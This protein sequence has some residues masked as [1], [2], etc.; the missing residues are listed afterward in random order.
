MEETIL[1]RNFLYLLVP[2]A[3]CLA[4]LSGCATVPVEQ[5]R[6]GTGYKPSSICYLNIKKVV[7][8]AGHGGYDPGAIGRTGLKEKDVN[9]DLAKKLRRLLEDQG[10]Q[11]VMTRSSDEYVALSKRVEIANKSHADL[12]ISMHANANRTRSLNGFE[13]YYVSPSANDPKRAMNAAHN[14]ALNLN[15][16]YFAARSTNL[17]AILWDMIYTDSRAESIR[18]ARSICRS[19]DRDSSVR[20]IGVKGANFYVL[21]GATIPAILVEIGFLSNAAEE[22]LLRSNSYRQQ[23]AVAIVDGLNQYAKSLAMAEEVRK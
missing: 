11:V 17:K 4:A 21:R 7:I 9:L 19:I 22:R 5:G 23:I 15:P 16:D 18:L 14:I 20:V 10:V 3:L 2:C 12:F 6:P 13:I 8:D 1:K